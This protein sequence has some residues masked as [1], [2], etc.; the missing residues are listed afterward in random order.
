MALQVSGSINANAIRSEFGATNGTSVR[1]GA[2]RVSQTVSGLE[3]LPLDAGI[4]QSGPIKFSDFYSKKLNVVVDYTPGSP[5]TRVNARTDY[6]ENNSRIVVIGN[7]RQRPVSPAG[8]KVWIHTNGDI[9]SDI[10]APIS[11]DIITTQPQIEISVL[12]TTTREASIQNFIFFTPPS[13]SGYPTLTF[14]GTENQVDFYNALLYSNVQYTI[15]GNPGLN[16]RLNGSTI[17]EADDS[18]NEVD[19]NDLILTLEDEVGSFYSIDGVIYYKFT[20]SETSVVTSASVYSSLKTGTWDSTTDLRLDIGPNGRV[21]GAGGDGG[22]GGDASGRSSSRGEN[23]KSGTS[24]I[25]IQYAPITITNRGFIIAGFGGGGGGG[26]GWGQDVDRNIFGITGRQTVNVGGSGGGGGRGL[27]GGRGGLGGSAS[28]TPN[29]GNAG[30]SGNINDGG[31]GGNGVGFETNS[32]CLA[33]GGGGGGGGNAGSGGD[34]ATAG[35][36]RNARITQ[37][38]AD[39]SAGIPGTLTQGGTGGTGAGAGDNGGGN[40]SGGGNGGSSGYAIVNGTGSTLSVT[41]NII[42]N[43]SPINT[44]PV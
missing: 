39:A 25:G 3:D 11:G 35:N 22:K 16:L 5:V 15:S 37:G 28:S 34:K 13:G 32:D 17:V 19:Y 36:T 24:A 38:Q 18:A 8:T 6:G 1:F 30:N 40:G 10:N 7:F 9:G 2:Y 33:I 14:T 29:P 23:G 42:G 4:P 43:I 41:G 21:A 20:F 12:F 27:P 31:K 26:G 44:T